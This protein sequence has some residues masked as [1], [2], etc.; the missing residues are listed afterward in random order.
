MI[1]FWRRGIAYLGTAF[2]GAMLLIAG[3]VKALDPGAFAEQIAGDVER[4]APWSHPAAVAVIAIEVMLGTIFLLGFRRRWLVG[5]GLMLVLVFIAITVP[6]IGKPDAGSCGCFGNFVVRTPAET[7]TEDLLMLGGLLLG[8]AGGPGSRLN[9]WRSTVIGTALALG[10]GV[11]ALSPGLPLDDFATRLKPG[12]SVRDLQLLEL[13]P[14]LET[15]RH[16]VLLGNFDALS[17]DRLPMSFT[18]FADANADAGY[19]IFK[20]ATGAADAGRTHLGWLCQPGSEMVGIPKTVARP[21]YRTLPRSF[22]IVDG[23]VVRTW[24]GLPH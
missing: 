19:W 23:S 24:N 20:P 14:E 15:G 18:A 13:V 11:P 3:L 12:A 17:C 10:I 16:I 9:G 8:L 2:A 21:L 5:A 22:E 1:P 4:L 6:K 7:V